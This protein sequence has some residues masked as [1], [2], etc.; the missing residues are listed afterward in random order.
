MLTPCKWWMN[1][2]LVGKWLWLQRSEG[3][4]DGSVFADIWNVKKKFQHAHTILTLRWHYLLLV[5]ISFGVCIHITHT[6]HNIILCIFFFSFHNQP[7]MDW[8]CMSL[9]VHFICVRACVYYTATS[10]Y[11][12]KSIPVGRGRKWR[13]MATEG[14][15]VPKNKTHI[16]DKHMVWQ[17]EIWHIQIGNLIYL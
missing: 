2:P 5:L 3:I 10:V 17:N 7:V 11:E 14:G 1:I 15:H 16:Y 9:C 6:W 12:W 8:F 4:D 13:R